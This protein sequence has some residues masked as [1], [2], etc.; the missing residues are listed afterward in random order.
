MRDLFI[1]VSPSSLISVAQPKRLKK[2]DFMRGEQT[3]LPRSKDTPSIVGF[4]SVPMLA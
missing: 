1:G 4:K 2:F 3:I